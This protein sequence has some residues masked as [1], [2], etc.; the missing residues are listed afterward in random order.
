ML[1]DVVERDEAFFGGARAMSGD[2]AH[3]SPE[4][5]IAGN[6]MGKF[7]SRQA[8]VSR[9]PHQLQH[10]LRRVTLDDA[11][12]FRRDGPRTKCSRASLESVTT[13]GGVGCYVRA[14]A[15]AAS[16]AVAGR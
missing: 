14:S 15:M 10:L 8:S 2:D 6:G 9:G 12:G 13:L 16:F 11:E 7:V 1:H 5:E 3:T 4:C